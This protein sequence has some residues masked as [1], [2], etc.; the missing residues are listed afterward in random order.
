MTNDKW[1]REGQGGAEAGTAR[2]SLLQH[3]YRRLADRESRLRTI[4]RVF[5]KARNPCGLTFDW[6]D[7]THGQNFFPLVAFD[8]KKIKK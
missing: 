2:Y 6:I 4:T 1:G 3:M 7:G 5:A 8:A